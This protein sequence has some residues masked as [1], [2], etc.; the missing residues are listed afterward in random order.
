MVSLKLELGKQQHAAQEAEAMRQLCQSQAEDL[1]AASSHS[2][3]LHDQ[4]C[5]FGD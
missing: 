3:L 4:V 2:D 5:C 1:A